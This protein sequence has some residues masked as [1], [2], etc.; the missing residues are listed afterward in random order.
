MSNLPSRFSTFDSIVINNDQG[1][2]CLKIELPNSS[3]DINVRN[4][5]SYLKCNGWI[6]YKFKEY[7]IK[8]LEKGIKVILSYE[9]PKVK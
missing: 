2:K 9:L 1:D 6:D 7:S 3:E 8:T 5:I 4:L